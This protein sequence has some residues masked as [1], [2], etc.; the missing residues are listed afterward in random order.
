MP[1]V[2]IVIPAFNEEKYIGRLL[3]SLYKLPQ[4]NILEII[5]VDNKSTDKTR[6]V[7]L[8]FMKTQPL[9]RLVEESKKGVMWARNRCVEEARGEVIAFLD[10]D[11]YVGEKWLSK[12]NDCFESGEVVCLSGPSFYYDMSLLARVSARMYWW[13][14][15]TFV[16]KITGYLGNFA[17][18][19]L[20]AKSLK[21]VGGIDTSIEFYGDDTNVPRRLSKVG[22]V[23]F[24]TRFFVH[25]S[26][27]RFNKE[28]LF[29]TTWTY[30]R[31]FFSEALVHK[32][33]TK[34]YTEVR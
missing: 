19:A 13:F 34:G 29:R 1:S 4:E 3:A 25:A 5:V 18:L 33:V 23:I 7:V 2:S 16:Y 21:E 22:K 20:R 30:A 12:I 24:T 8:G 32:P 9:L 15:A 31:G 14:A 11:T 26:A 27:R 17:N 10:A 6:E 28:G